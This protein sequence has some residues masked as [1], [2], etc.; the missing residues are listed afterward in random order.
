M[1]YFLILLFFHIITYLSSSCGLEGMW[2]S[3]LASRVLY[4]V[5][6]DGRWHWLT[7]LTFSVLP[8]IQ[9][10]L[11]TV[12]I[13]VE[14]ISPIQNYTFLAN[15]ELSLKPVGTVYLQKEQCLGPPCPYSFP[16]WIA[17]ISEVLLIAINQ[18]VS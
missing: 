5:F 7:Q 9:L 18:D 12:K 3:Y 11:C 10:I 6:S 8:W 17:A 16:L 14:Y 15:E 13:Y 2:D 4:L 1:L